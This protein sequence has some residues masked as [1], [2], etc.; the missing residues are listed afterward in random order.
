M[1]Q[2]LSQLGLRRA[3][4]GTHARDEGRQKPFPQLGRAESSQHWLLPI[5][6]REDGVARADVRLG[7]VQE[8]PI[9]RHHTTGQ[10]PMVMAC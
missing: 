3:A 9:I 8:V 5:I 4:D 7:V 10:F 6:L 2:L 1:H